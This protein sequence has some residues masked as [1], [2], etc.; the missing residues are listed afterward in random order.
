MTYPLGKKTSSSVSPNVKTG[1]F[2][3]KAFLLGSLWFVTQRT[4][5]L[6]EVEGAV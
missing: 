3:E 5:Q 1:G 2:L 4:I 6:P